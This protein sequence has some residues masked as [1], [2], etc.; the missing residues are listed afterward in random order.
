[1]TISGNH[2]CSV[3][4]SEN[5]TMGN[6][7]RQSGKKWKKMETSPSR[8]YSTR[9]WTLSTSSSLVLGPWTPPYSRSPR[10]LLSSKWGRYRSHKWSSSPRCPEHCLRYRSRN[11]FGCS[12]P[13]NARHAIFCL[14]SSTHDGRVAKSM[15]L[16]SK[17]WKAKI[18]MSSIMEQT[19]SILQLDPLATRTPSSP[20]AVFRIQSWLPLWW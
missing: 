2:S 19:W 3:M 11:A 13:N 9:T 16:Q 20:K 6:I 8:L 7:E 4:F 5:L 17:T 1:M 18:S 14:C 15:P 10:Y 12:A